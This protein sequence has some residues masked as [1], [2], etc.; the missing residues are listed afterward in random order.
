MTYTTQERKLSKL[1]I[2][3]D[4]EVTL[5]YVFSI[6]R[7]YSG[8]TCYTDCDENV[9]STLNHFPTKKIIMMQYD[10]PEAHQETLFNLS[11]KKGIKGIVN[12]ISNS[13]CPT[14][15]IPIGDIL[16]FDYYAGFWE[17]SKNME[18]NK[19]ISS[20]TPCDM[21][22][23]QAFLDNKKLLK[24]TNQLDEKNNEI[25]IIERRLELGAVVALLSILFSHKFSSLFSTSFYLLNL[26]LIF[27]ELTEY[28]NNIEQANQMEKMRDSIVSNHTL[29]AKING[30]PP[31]LKLKN[32]II[33]NSVTPSIS[34][35]LGLSEEF[36]GCGMI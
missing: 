30:R 24:I 34:D 12:G 29:F 35:Y 4:Y 6:P 32:K 7:A 16:H 2:E 31:L 14:K 17:Y 3:A 15:K 28:K 5:D 1:Y 36:V 11:Q 22:L 8:Y 18:T 27:N 9:T 25:E 20:F 10:I 23:K 26:E 21:F 33:D 13:F 19:I